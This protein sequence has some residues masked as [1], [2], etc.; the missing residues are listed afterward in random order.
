MAGHL[1]LVG[2]LVDFDVEV[3]QPKE[4]LE[5]LGENDVDELLDDQKDRAEERHGKPHEEAEP[6][7]EQLGERRELH[8]RHVN[9]LHVDDQLRGR[10]GH[11]ANS[12]VARA[13]RR[14]RSA[15]L[16][17]ES[18]PGAHRHSVRRA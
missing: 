2:A 12:V 4:R 8:H 1:Q 7:L 17:P 13:V 5:Q 18:S 15:H 16:Q 11:G 9:V 14:L 10:C 6:D 3:K